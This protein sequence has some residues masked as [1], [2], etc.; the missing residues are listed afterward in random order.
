V[1]PDPALEADRIRDRERYAEDPALRKRKCDSANRYVART[2]STLEGYTRIAITASRT[3]TSS[4]G[5]PHNIDREYIVSLI[6]TGGL[7]P[8]FPWVKM[9]FARGA[10]DNRDESASLDRIIPELGYTRGNVRWISDRANRLRR[11]GCTREFEALA[12]DSAAIEKS[13]PTPGG[14]KKEEVKWLS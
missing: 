3:R 8:V 1:T 5:Q 14:S 9:R 2:A 12:R 13:N 4:T 11:D 7:C 10:Y 6:P